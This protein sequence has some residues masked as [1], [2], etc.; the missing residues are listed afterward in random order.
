M[1]HVLCL[2]P[3]VLILL[4]AILLLL[5]LAILLLLMV[6]RA[7]ITARRLSSASVRIRGANGIVWLGAAAG[8]AGAR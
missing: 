3:P 2:V 4:L 1:A 7:R 5:L 6:P 8:A